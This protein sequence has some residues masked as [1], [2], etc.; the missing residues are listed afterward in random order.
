MVSLQPRTLGD[1]ADVSEKGPRDSHTR[2]LGHTAHRFRLVEKH[3]HGNRPTAT[4]KP[5]FGEAPRAVALIGTY[6]PTE[7]GIATFTQN[8]Q[9]A[10]ASST[11]NW[12]TG[13]L[14]VMERP[15]ERVFDDVVVAQWLRDDSA[16]LIE[17]IAVL[18]TFDAVIVQ[19][20]YGLF[21][22]TDGDHI[23]DLLAGVEVPIIA[24][25]HTTLETP[26]NHQ[27]FVL[28]HILSMADRVVVQ[29]EAA[30]RRV[31]SVHGCDLDDVAVI[32][33]GAAA[34]FNGAKSLDYDGPI[35]LTWGLLSP[36]KGIEYGIHAIAE[37]QK[38][39]E[40]VRY[41]VAGQTHPKVLRQSGERYRDSLRELARSKGAH[42]AV[43]FD[44][45]YRDWNALRALVRS[46][47]VVLLPYESRDQVSSG[48]LVEALASGKP[49]VATRFPHAEE[50]L[51]CGAGVVVDHADA[52]AMADAI[53]E[54]LSDE[55]LAKEM[56]TAARFVAQGLLWPT[57]GA[58][59]RTLLVSLIKKEAVA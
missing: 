14:R 2:S 59:Y 56:H 53:K 45:E 18:N 15:D 10:I 6:P 52:D 34:N 32:A 29:S 51:A 17:S 48:V 39:I 24:V 30:K 55:S 33:H 7:C 35:V 8:L 22:G 26:S 13:V 21:G 44:D 37:V 54:I 25:L 28:E 5:T 3:G 49:V 41:V 50:L 20:E 38:T 36:G 58:L 42:D 23:L 9:S 1:N 57:V 40:N 11:T 47:D 43:I 16:S 12:H 4:T 19:H 27:R 31:V 46:A